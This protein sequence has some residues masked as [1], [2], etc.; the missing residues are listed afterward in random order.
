MG[1]TEVCTP[2]VPQDRNTYL[3]TSGVRREHTISSKRTAPLGIGDACMYILMDVANVT[4][5][6]WFELAQDKLGAGT[7]AINL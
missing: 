6:T 3:S 2:K 5:V 1:R 4:N 7:T